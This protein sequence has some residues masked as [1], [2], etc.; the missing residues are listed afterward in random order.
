MGK[1]IS[2]RGVFPPIPTPFDGDGDLA[3]SALIDNIQRWNEHDLSG[4]VVL[5][6]N[7]EGVY[8]S[9]EEKVRVWHAARRAIPEGKLLRRRRAPMWFSW[10]LLTTMDP[11]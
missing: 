10:S 4:Y 11:R 1:P 9:M 3:I 2:L 5:G 6:S 8:L 7:G